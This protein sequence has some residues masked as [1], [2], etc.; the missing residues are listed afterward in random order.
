[1]LVDLLL[2]K[3]QVF[4]RFLKHEL[5][6]VEVVHA[7]LDLMVQVK[8]LISQFLKHFLICSSRHVGGAQLLTLQ[9]QHVDLLFIVLQEL[10]LFLVGQC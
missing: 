9:P 1:M 10:L 2:L 3:L 6:L 7:L 5:F 4:L 8:V